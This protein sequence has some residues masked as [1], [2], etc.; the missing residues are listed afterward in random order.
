ML[1]HTPSFCYEKDLASERGSEREAVSRRCEPCLR[2]MG[3][4]AQHALPGAHA[5]AGGPMSAWYVHCARCIVVC[6]LCSRALCSLA[7]PL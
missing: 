6:A 3:V 2:A 7:L 4:P 1:F 5:G